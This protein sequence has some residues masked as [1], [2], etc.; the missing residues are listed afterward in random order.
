MIADPRSPD[1][2]F[3]DA[4]ALVEAHL[5]DALVRVPEA[6]AFAAR[7]R[8]SCGLRLGDMLDH[9]AMQVDEAAVEAAGW[10]RIDA[11][12]WRHREGRLPDFVERPRRSIGFRVESVARFLEANGLGSPV[13]GPEHGPYR[14]ARAFAA[15]SVAF[16]AVERAAWSGYDPPPVNARRAR[17]ARIHLQ[18]FRTRTRTFRRAVGFQH[19]ER[20]VEAA[21][22]DLG[23]HW[24]C[25]LFMRAERE[26]WMR[27][28]DAGWLQARRQNAMGVGWC[29]PD[30][31]VYAASRDHAHEAIVILRKLGFQPRA[32]MPAADGHGAH[33]LLL[34]QPALRTAAF[35]EVDLGPGEADIDLSRAML[36]P[37][38]AHG[39]A[40]LWCA[41]HGE[42][43]LEGGL[44]RAGLLCDVGALRH[45][46]AHEGIALAAPLSAG[47][48]LVRQRTRPQWRAVEPKRADSL[49][50]AGQVTRGQAEQ[51]RLAGAE[52]AAFELVER[53]DA[54][55]G[56]EAQEERFAP[57]RCG[58]AAE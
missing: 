22:A 31:D 19:T 27:R 6:Q 24:A 48:R 16:D 38:T 32:V 49:E 11:S 43:M 47:A 46:L 10:R 58:V 42:S 20:L 45:V 52:A 50:R 18:I 51:M 41:A 14:R 25:A 29:A 36:S 54:C 4:A 37:L 23:P 5:A 15:A 44:V 53:H 35:V 26:Y 28:C 7:L 40:G 56:Y 13:E 34:E 8:E 21:C 9:I 30:H 33:A 55:T 3:P 17:R 2:A 1:A 12:V 57:G 39:R